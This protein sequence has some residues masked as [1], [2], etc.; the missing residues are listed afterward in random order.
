MKQVVYE[1]AFTGCVL[2]SY[3]R[4]FK[5]RHANH[6]YSTV[7]LGPQISVKT[8]QVGVGQVLVKDL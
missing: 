5:C 3:L 1:E 8:T 6:Y 2:N 7:I 4:L